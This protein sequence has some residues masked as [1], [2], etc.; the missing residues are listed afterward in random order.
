MDDACLKLLAKSKF[1]LKLEEIY[2]D[3]CDVITDKGFDEF[4]KSQ[5][6][7]NVRILGLNNCDN[8]TD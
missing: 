2:L 3:S 4:V 5:I 7:S 6:M 1:L 8:L